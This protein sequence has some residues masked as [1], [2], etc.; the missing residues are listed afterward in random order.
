MSIE[1]IKKLLS[2]T[3]K[4]GCTE[5]EAM[6]AA[7]KA[8]RLM[9]QLGIEEADL[10]FSASTVNVKAGWSSGRAELWRAISVC[11]NTATIMLGGSIEYVGRDPW[12][13]VAQYLHQVTSRAIDTALREFK[14]GKWYRRRTSIR[15]KRAAA[16]DFT[17]AMAFRL[18]RK[19][20]A[21]FDISIDEDVRATALIERDRRYPTSVDVPT[22]NRR[23]KLGRY[24]V[25]GLAG[26]AAA[27]GVELSHGVAA[28]AAPLQIAGRS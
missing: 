1:R 21:L 20:V 17:K 2:M 3:V 16:F 12:P 13:T 10:Q 24:L 14:A 6:A 26:V 4:A 18:S 19:L 9:A 7:E 28:D 15:A 25:A 8:A 11:T 5:A 23:P 27:D 22:V